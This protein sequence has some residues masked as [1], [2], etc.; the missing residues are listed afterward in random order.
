MLLKIGAPCR[1]I[2]GSVTRSLRIANAATSANAAASVY[3]THMPA[4]PTITPPMAGPSTM[5]D[6]NTML[7]RLAP[8]ANCGRGSTRANSAL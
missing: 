3:A 8:R 4:A 2:A 7:P 5:A 1:V 6:W